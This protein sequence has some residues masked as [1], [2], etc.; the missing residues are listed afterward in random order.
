MNSQI[1]GTRRIDRSSRVNHCRANQYRVHDVDH[2]EFMFASS[3]WRSVTEMSPPPADGRVVNSLLFA[4]HG[5]TIINCNCCWQTSATDNISV[6][7][8]GG[9]NCNITQRHV[10]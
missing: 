4:G 7:Q 9:L 8:N 1:H 5:V 6:L 3:W 2:D 10:K